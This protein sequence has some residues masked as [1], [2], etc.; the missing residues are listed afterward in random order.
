MI[1]NRKNTFLKFP[2]LKNKNL[3]M[4]IS[5]DYDGLI[6]SS[7]LNH[8]LNWELVGFYDLNKIWLSQKAINKKN[9]LIW[10][11]LNILPQQGKAI[12]GH[13]VSIDDNIPKGFESSCNPNILAKINAKKFKSKFPFSTLIYLL[14]L[15]NKQI[16]KDNLSK[17]LIL[18]SDATWLKYQNYPE[19]CSSWQNKMSDFKWEQLFKNISSK[20][21][22][23]DIDQN[24]YP[25]LKSLGAISSTSKLTSKNLNIKSRQLQFNPD[26]DEDVILNLFSLFA[27]N[28]K[29][30]I[31]KLPDIVRLIEGSRKKVDLS[32]IKTLGLNSFIK[33]NKVFSYAISS[34][35][36]LNFTTFKLSS[37]SK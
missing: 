19:N 12:G 27:E 7:F 23:K 29:W 8:F 3:P 25:L 22:E 36:I 30:S 5:A 18:H 35:R 11:D 13:I 32:V 10:V 14:W 15:H 20:K 28:L 6:C 16:P 4:V 9:D 26:W 31:P 37:F 17:F 24:F 2:W 34:P 33:K 1:F 21:F